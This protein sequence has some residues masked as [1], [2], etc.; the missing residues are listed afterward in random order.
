MGVKTRS[1]R[2]IADSKKKTYRARVKRSTCKNKKPYACAASTKCKIAK[3]KKRT[4]CRKKKNT[5][6]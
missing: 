1:V 2:K 6:A 3:G 5:K 4:F